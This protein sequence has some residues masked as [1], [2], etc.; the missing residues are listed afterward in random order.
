M[1]ATFG[2]SIDGEELSSQSILDSEETLNVVTL[3]TIM[4]DEFSIVDEYLSKLKEELEVS[5]REPEI[6]IAKDEEK[7]N[8]MRL[9]VIS[10]TLEEPQKESKKDQPLVPDELPNMKEGM[11]VAL[12]K[13]IDVSFVVDISK[14][15]EIT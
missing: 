1:T 4:L 2:N 6:I 11:H 9:E 8:E 7:E 13:A 5:L 15:E 12:P 3:K 14:G 10:K